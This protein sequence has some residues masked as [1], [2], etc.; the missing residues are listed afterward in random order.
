MDFTHSVNDAKNGSIDSRVIWG[1]SFYR[2]S[3]SIKDHF[4]PSKLSQLKPRILSLCA[5]WIIEFLYQLEDSPQNKKLRT[6]FLRRAFSCYKNAAIQGDSIGQL[7]VGMFYQLGI[8]TKKNLSE[9]MIWIK[10]A[11]DQGNSE[12]QYQMARIFDFGL[13]IPRNS[14]EAWP[15]YILAGNQ[16]NTQS[17]KRLGQ[18]YMHGHGVEVDLEQSAKWYLLAAKQGDCYS[19]YQI[20][21]MHKIGKGLP[22]DPSAAIRWL[23]LAAEQGETFAMD[24]LVEIHRD[25]IGTEKNTA[26]AFF[27]ALIH[28]KLKPKEFIFGKNLE[29]ELTKEEVTKIQSQVNLW[30]PRIWNDLRKEKLLPEN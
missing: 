5:N 24:Y 9:A 30:K 20:G 12:A 14:Q 26:N 10:K 18:I 21:Y 29:N 23:T 17:Q 11:A 25:G 2:A 16:G 6:I 15:W 28:A 3:L 8:G 4:P 19:Q 27:W 13:G 1:D 22:H 7:R